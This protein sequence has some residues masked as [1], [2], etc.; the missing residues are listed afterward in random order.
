MDDRKKAAIYLLMLNRYKELI[1]EKE[2]KTITEIR[3][4]TEPNKPF[5]N[6]LLKRIIPEWPTIGQLEAINRIIGYFR[7]IET[8]EFSLT[9]WL[10]PEEIDEIRAADSPNKALLFVA[11]L[12]SLGVENAKVYITKSGSYYA[13][14]SLQGK[15]YLFLP[16][17]NALVENEEI[18]KIFAEDPPTCAFN[19]LNYENFEE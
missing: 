15:N 3:K 5:L 7:T 1:N 13:G 14:F 6:H 16:K 4:M 8:C 18:A 10:K 12:R 17:N 11:L 2:T 19:D 9:F